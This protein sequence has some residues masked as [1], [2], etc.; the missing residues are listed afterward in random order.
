MKRITIMLY[1]IINYTLGVAALNYL[2]VFLFNLFVPKT[3]DS[4]D[5]GN[6]GLVYST[7]LWQGQNSRPG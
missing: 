1:S 6:A 5:V 7:V 2:I 3:I 4:G